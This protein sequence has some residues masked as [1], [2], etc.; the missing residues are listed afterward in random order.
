MF[1]K[2][3][4]LALA[5]AMGTLARYALAGFVHRFTGSA[6]PWGTLVVNLVGC[7]LA[8]LLWVLFES[9]WSVSGETRTLVLVGFMG[10]FTTF[11]AMILETGELARSAQWLYAGANVGMQTGLGFVALFVGMAAGRAI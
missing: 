4:W 6:F 5:G 10:A 7:F 1:H 3:M 2:L 9:R 8:G 11:S